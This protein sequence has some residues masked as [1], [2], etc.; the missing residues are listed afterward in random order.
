MIASYDIRLEKLR[1]LI[2]EKGG[3]GFIIPKSDPFQGEYIAP[4]DERLAW[5][6]GFHGSAGTAVVL[7]DKAALFVDG[8]YTLQAQKQ[9]DLSL[10]EV[11][12]VPETS[13]ESWL[14]K[15]VPIGSKIFL[16]PWLHTLSQKKHFD[17]VLSK[18][19]S[20]LEFLSSNL[21]DNLWIDRPNPPME[22]VYL[23]DLTYAGQSSA[24]KRKNVSDKLIEQSV[25]C[26]LLSRLD[27]I[28]WLLNVR[29]SDIPHTPVVQGFAILWMDSS[30]D[31]FINPEKVPQDVIFA[32]GAGVRIHSGETI[33]DYLDS[34]TSKSI[35]IDP[36][37]TPLIFIEKLQGKYVEGKD[38]CE[39]LKAIKN[40]TE[41]RG[42]RNAHLRD[43]IALS[44]FLACLTHQVDLSEE[45]TELSAAEKLLSFRQK[46]DLF[47]DLSFET[48][49][50]F[51]PNGA[52]VHYRVTPESNQYIETSGIYLVDSGAQYLD[53]TTDVTR[54]IAIGQPSE[55]Q[56]D[57][58]TRVLKGHIALASVIFPKGTTGSQLD[59]L[60]RQFLWEAGL[61]YAHGTGHGVGSFL[62]VHEGPQ[63]I[64][65]AH[66]T[67]PLV[68]GM[69]L[70]NEPGYYKEG[71][72]GIRIEN[73]VLV[74]PATDVSGAEHEMYAFETL[75]LAPIDL[76]LVMP[77]MLTSFERDWL[78]TY[79]DRVREAL[80]PHV[81]ND[82]AAWLMT[83]TEAI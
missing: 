7:K 35:L 20:T 58:F 66:S 45:V 4:C 46:N 3:D 83:A 22:P 32:L 67:C 79:H 82:T 64:S 8:R 51:G 15:N 54:T 2:E 55:E 75:T 29:G 68:P 23:H 50:G 18:S 39:H 11:V 33:L 60:A 81:D 13:L 69:I 36:N 73:L 37:H 56:R 19:Q 65:K 80:M 44:N 48:I 14:E 1:S 24:S 12:Q 57:R 62:S 63:R 38:P 53:G 77:E 21:I 70:S 27:S 30:V 52:I 49:S 25:E 78:N 28:A 40:Q 26:V 42:T 34:L 72:Y 10:Y 61:D 47:Q 16:D 17:R 9:V 6:T 59:I 5:L 74:V 71:E 31:W 76:S 41:I 43:G